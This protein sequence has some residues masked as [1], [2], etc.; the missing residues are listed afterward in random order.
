M[1]FGKLEMC[2]LPLSLEKGRTHEERIMAGSIDWAS[3]QAFL[4]LAREE[5]L[6][7]AAQRAGIDHGTLKRRITSLER[8][9]GVILF[10]R[11]PTGY[12]LTSSGHKTLQAVE[13]MESASDRKGE[14]PQSREKGRTNEERIMAGSID[15]ASLQAFLTLAR[16][17]RLTI[18]AQRAGIDH[19]TL[20]RR[21]TSLERA[22]GVILFERKPTGYLLTSSGHKTLQAV[23][24][25]ESASQQL[26]Q[27]SE[28]LSI[29]KR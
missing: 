3:L 27:T 6:T 14:L 16:E 13:E 21:I 29:G 25:M 11:K 5:R 9:L 22:L 28:E 1:A 10:E 24:E 8:A 18:A 15:W 19:G 2:E 23:E 17:E 12:L 20:K 7:I 26:P 4:T